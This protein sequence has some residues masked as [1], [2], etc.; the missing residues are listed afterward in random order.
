MKSK[1]DK[2]LQ[3]EKKN[4]RLIIVSRLL[5]ATYLCFTLYFMFFSESMGR[6]IGD[7]YRYNLEP[8]LEIK[9]FYNLIGGDMNIRACINLFGNVI[10][11]IPFGIFLPAIG[12]HFKSFVRVTILAAFFSLFIESIQLYFKIGIFDVDDLM[13]NTLGGMIGYII[14][15]IYSMIRYRWQSRGKCNE[16]EKTWL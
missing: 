5:F 7:S 14:Y 10:C 13:L 1:N 3:V 9:R 8:F 6:N 15:K 12:G 2:K 11:F 16:N 4:K